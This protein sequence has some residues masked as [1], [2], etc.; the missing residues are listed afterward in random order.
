MIVAATRAGASAT[1]CAASRVVTCSST[2]RSPGKSR[3]IAAR[4][5]LDEHALAIEH[6]DVGVG[7]LAV[8]RQH[9]AEALHRRERG[10]DARRAT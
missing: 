4:C 2:M 3:T 5:A 6:V 1:N 10:I 8:E 7:D 9:D